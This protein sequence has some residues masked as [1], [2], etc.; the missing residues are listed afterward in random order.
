MKMIKGI[1][2]VKE[3]ILSPLTNAL[4]IILKVKILELT[5]VTRLN[6]TLFCTIIMNIVFWRVS[7]GM[8]LLC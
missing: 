1:I 2:I 5:L 4:L 3:D 6:L 7:T 8:G